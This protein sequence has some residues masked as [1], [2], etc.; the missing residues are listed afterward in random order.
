MLCLFS[1]IVDTLCK[2]PSNSSILRYDSISTDSSFQCYKVS[3]VQSRSLVRRL[4]NVEPESWHWN[5]TLSVPFYKSA[6]ISM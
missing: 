6:P 2:I 1:A 4:S 5:G 3:L